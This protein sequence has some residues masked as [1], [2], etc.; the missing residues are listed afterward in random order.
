LYYVNAT[1]DGGVYTIKQEDLAGSYKEFTALQG[2][3]ID[4][5]DDAI[6]VPHYSFAYAIY[7]YENDITRLEPDDS[8]TNRYG[9]ILEYYY[10]LETFEIEAESLVLGG[11]EGT[12]SIL[13]EGEYYY[14]KDATLKASMSAGYTFV[15]WYRTSDLPAEPTYDTLPT[16]KCI[17]T[18]QSM[19]VRVTSDES[20]T[21]VMLASD[22][23]KP[24]IT[25]SGDNSYRYN[26]PTDHVLTAVAEFGEDADPASYVSGYQWYL[27][28]EA[29]SGA[30]GV[31]YK[32]PSDLD[33]G[34]YE[35]Y[36]EV[37]AQRK[38]N[39]VSEKVKSGIFKL[40]VEKD[41]LSGYTTAANHTAV[42]DAK[43]DHK[44]T[45]EVKAP[46]SNIY[47]IYYS[48]EQ[49]LTK[50]NYTEGV[51]TMPTFK[52][53]KVDADGN[54]ESYKVY[55]YV[56]ATNDNYEDCSGSRTVKITP[57]QLT[58]SAGS[59]SYS[60]VYDGSATVSGSAG[61]DGEGTDLYKLTHSTGVY[62]INGLLAS[63]TAKG[64][65]ISCGAEF[66]SSHTT[67][68]TAVTLADI[69][70]ADQAG[71]ILHNYAFEKSYTVILSGYIE[72]C[73]LELDWTNT[74]FDFNGETHKPTAAISGEIP[75]CD[76]GNLEVSVSGEQTYV[77]EWNAVAHLTSKD[78]DTHVDDYS[79]T[80]QSKT[81]KIKQK[82]ISFA[83]VS[84]TVGYDGAKHTLSQSTIT[85]G[86][87]VDG[88]SY[89]L[90]ADSK[91]IHKGKY[92]IAPANVVITDAA[93]ADVTENYKITC[94]ST[95]ELTINART[96]TVSNIKAENK[97]YDG[98]TAAELTLSDIAFAGIIEGDTL[99]LDSDKV[100]GTFDTKDAGEGKTVNISYAAG[101][102]TGASASDYV[103]DTDQS[104]QTATADI[105]KG[106]ILVKATAV[107]TV[108]GEIPTFGASFSGFI[109]GEDESVISGE[110][111]YVVGS[112]RSSAAA[113]TGKEHKGTYNIYP[114]VT[115]LSADN[116]TFST[117]DGNLIIA[118]RPVT[119]AA[120]DG[121]LISKTY[122]GTTD[123]KTALVNGTHYEFAGVAGDA[124]SGITNGDTV[125]L[126]YTAAY[127]EKDP[128]ERTITVNGLS[129]DN[130]DYK[131][132]T[133]SFTIDGE[134]TRKTIKVTANKKT[135]TYGDAA[136]TYTVSYSGFEHGENESVLSGT[137][138]FAC[139]YDTS[140]PSKRGVGK[141]TI[142][143]SGLTSD[144]YQIDFVDNE[145]VV[146]P[147][148]ITLSTNTS[149]DTLIYGSA[150]IPTFSY[151]PSGF[152]Y[153]DD[154][155]VISIKDDTV[156]YIHGLTETEVEYDGSTHM[157]VTS[158][159]DD[160]S[161]TLEM[162]RGGDPVF[163][164]TNYSFEAVP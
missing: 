122:D 41:P 20:Y 123:V 39:G 112:S 148:K 33:A 149:A 10:D 84:D 74:E 4:V 105:T 108:Y 145:L 111:T 146:N 32:L 121:A 136:P 48:T 116:Y 17:S 163:T 86:E 107:A 75:S 70:L 147:A 59:S 2:K 31:N 45:L 1:L 134:I 12:L 71:N 96:V 77:G 18:D 156:N 126:S 158:V 91:Y 40:T 102:L 24:T 11:T 65:I 115:G 21:A 92:N 57:V 87:L 125:T 101:A 26:S 151:T 30:T 154:A 106:E 16:D 100:S 141:Y 7:Q 95:G 29:I 120:V 42:Y 22:V 114:V 93:G 109:T 14:G 152:K 83:M 47:E 155:T 159:P 144:D 135:I 94:E 97:E 8:Y 73:P 140:D 23:D 69:V 6:S 60:K 132:E 124:A 19:S 137:L 143:P 5:A 9:M 162:T 28:G 43:N 130:D 113:Y 55:Y 37:T 35:L 56:K 153:D 80:N 54:V 44:I 63:D 161:V 3:E 104:Q 85:S 110:V 34:D 138:A 99:S 13:G 50:D 131:L 38:D 61:P 157:V 27:N 46:E 90:S 128:L 79:I 118:Q 139:D 88:H 164:A 129:L 15:G 160:Y 78:A 81:F 103:L 52:D 142:T 119:V 150:G 117:E 66:N 68:A 62:T 36:C 51:Q 72:R 53:V 127:D 64:Y 67:D 25:I 98:T 82:E 76:D 89:T 49:A 58:L 133:E